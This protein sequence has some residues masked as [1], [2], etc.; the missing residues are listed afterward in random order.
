MSPKMVEDLKI[1]SEVADNLVQ[2]AI[3]RMT[4][5]EDM[6]IERSFSLRIE[7]CAAPRERIREAVVEQTVSFFERRSIKVVYNAKYRSVSLTFNLVSVSFNRIQAEAF[8][9]RIEELKLPS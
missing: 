3:R 8:C 5:P 4:C 7:E 6:R 1:L 2:S 9:R